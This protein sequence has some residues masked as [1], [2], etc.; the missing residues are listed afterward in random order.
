M[1]SFVNQITESEEDEEDNDN[2]EDHKEG[3]TEPVQADADSQKEDALLDD[4]DEVDEDDEDTE[5][6]A[7]L[8]ENSKEVK[9][10]K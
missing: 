9:K 7:L 2:G 1:L 3:S 6:R 5:T 4:N 10:D 8:T